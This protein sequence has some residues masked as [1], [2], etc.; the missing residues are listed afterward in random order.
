MADW[1]I[2]LAPESDGIGEWKDGDVCTNPTSSVIT[3]V[4]TIKVGMGCG[5]GAVWLSS[6]GS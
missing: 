6:L 4:S 5:V 3:S 2:G 1:V